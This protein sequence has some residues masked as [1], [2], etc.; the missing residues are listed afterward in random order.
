[1]VLRTL[2]SA[3][4]AAA[5]FAADVVVLTLFLNPHATLRTDGPALLLC[6]FAPYWVAG[7]MAL[8]LVTVAGAAVVG[9]PRA[10]RPPIE[11][12]PWFTSLACCALAASGALFWANL[13]SYRYS[14]PVEFVRGLLG[15]AATCTGAL[16]VL[17][18]VGVEALLFPRRSRALSAALVVLASASSVVLPL[19]LVPLPAQAPAP[20]PLATETIAPARRVVLIGVDGLGPARLREGVAAGRLPALAQMIR[21]GAHGPLA[22]LRPTEGPPIWTTVFTGRLPRDHGIK[23]FTAYH[24]RGT[25]TAFEALPKGA[26]VGV[27]ERLGLVSRADVTASSRRKRA[28]WNALNA[29]GIETGVVRFWGTH[30]PERVKGFMLSHAFHRPAGDPVRAAEVLYP[31]DLLNEVWARVVEPQV[32]PAELLAEFVDPSAPAAVGQAWPWRR[33][34]VLRALAPDL[35]YHRAGEV[36]RNA[37]DPPFFATYFY[38]LDVVGHSFLRYAEPDRFGDVR[39]EEIRRYGR[40]L[41]RY[42]SLLDE[43]IGEA[44][45]EQKPGDVLLVV[46]GY[47]MQ[48]V[49][50]ARR[51]LTP[52]AGEPPLAGTHANAPDGVILMYGDG[53]R[54]GAMTSSASVLDVT[55]TVLYLM[56]LPVARDMEGRALTE[57]LDE[58]FTRGHP[59]T[60]IPSY[61]SL[62]VTPV[63]GRSDPGVP[64]APDEP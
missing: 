32:V 47:G 59:L 2:G 22:T 29:F 53:V 8:F 15:S 45:H 1:M 20:V 7:T 26:L 46:S 28:L 14:V 5:L 23:S 24:L 4:L 21:R 10:P 17:L 38:G 44:M 48:P 50:L 55:P 51:L 19:A 11:G 40:V 52:S 49:S 36:L 34:L 6:L 13:W 57:V 60:F 3:A 33:E 18:A 12:L 64:E 9:G 62:A 25:A 61:E 35:T 41:D 63:V 43:W 42:E 54:E 30:P 16:L 37:Y 31:P 27:L 39:P 56:G 58:D